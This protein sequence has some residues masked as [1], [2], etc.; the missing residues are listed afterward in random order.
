MEKKCVD[1]GSTENL[2]E[3]HI[4]YEPEKTVMLCVNCHKKRHNNNHGVGLAKGQYPRE[5]E[6]KDI[7]FGKLPN[8]KEE[9]KKFWR[10]GKTYEELKERFDVSFATINNWRKKLGLKTRLG[11]K[12]EEKKDIITVTI[13]EEIVEKVDEI[14]KDVDMSRSQVVE[15]L[16][17]K[18]FGMQESDWL[19]IRE[20]VIETEQRR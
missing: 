3:H 10:E 4:S 15:N 20:K 11:K 14:A 17:K 9:F 7:V 5:T 6:E 18:A 2:Q 12:K 19:E 16:V 1:C 13:E 8:V